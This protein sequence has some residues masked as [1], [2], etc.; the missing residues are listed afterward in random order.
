MLKKGFD[1]LLKSRKRVIDIIAKRYHLMIKLLSQ[2][3]PG[4]DLDPNGGA[5]FVLLNINPK[6]KA[7][8]LN[9]DLLQNF[10]T[11][12]IPLEDKKNGVNALR[13]AF[14]SIPVS[15]IHQAVESI[16]SSLQNLGL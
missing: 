5:F 6:V 3:L 1:T 4:T 14:S 16:K 2:P 10:Q 11:G 13:I 9:N 7:S 15:Q 8:D 12:F